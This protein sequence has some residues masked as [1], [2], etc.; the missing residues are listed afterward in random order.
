[1]SFAQ[2]NST[3]NTF[4]LFTFTY[5]L[6]KNSSLGEKSEEWRV[7]S[8]EWRGKKISS[9]QVRGIFLVA[10]RGFEPPDLR[11]MSPTS[12]QAALPRDIW[13]LPVG[14]GDRGRTGTILSYHG[15]LS[16]GRLPIPPHRRI[17]SQD[18]ANSRSAVSLYHTY[19]HLSTRLWKLLFFFPFLFFSP[20]L[21]YLFLY[22]FLDFCKNTEAT[23][24]LE[25]P[26]YFIIFPLGNTAVQVLPGVDFLFCFL[27]L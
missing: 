27:Y 6:Q 11:V 9:E 12:Y 14:A 18:F 8:E 1:M 17:A 15:I 16:P 10:G 13:F 25:Q 5:Y 4:S 2:R 20:S 21:P 22:I 24:F 23:R 26:R 7:K 19:I 3:E